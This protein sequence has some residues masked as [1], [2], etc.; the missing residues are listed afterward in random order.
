MSDKADER[1]RVEEALWE[2]E[3]RYRRLADNSPDM[4]FWMSLPDGKYEYVSPAAKRI[5]GHP[6]QTWYD[7]PLLLREILHPDYRSYFEKQWENLLKGDL[8]PSYEYKI[9]HKDGSVRWVNQRNILVK[10]EDNRPLAIEGIATNITERKQAEE[11]LRKSE[12][13]LRMTLDATP[14]P[15]AVVDLQDDKILFWSR[16]ALTFFGHTAPTASEWYQIAFPDSDYRREVIERWKPFLELARE[17]GQPVNTGEYR[18]T[19][20]DG[21]E[22]ICELHATFLSDYLIVT[23]NDITERK[24]PEEELNQIFSMSLDMICI[25]DINTASF[26]RINPAFTETLGFSEEELLGKPFIDFI[27]PD[28]IDSTRSVVENKLQMG[29]KVINFDNRYRCKDGSYR[30]L[31]W[32]SHPNVERGITYAVARDITERKRY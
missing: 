29:A 26:I 24:R 11:L 14:F 16:S 2:S 15:V 3:K 9:I 17:S 30:W 20:S 5:F 31:S 1:K 19:C 7:N 25:A 27:H 12:N 13:N 4:I 22:R 10:D 28:D 32:V 6:P 23:F 8:S 18:V 21:S